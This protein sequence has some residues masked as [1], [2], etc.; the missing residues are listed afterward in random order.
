MYTY[1]CTKGHVEPTPT[2]GALV[3]CPVLE[4]VFVNG[5]RRGAAPC[6]CATIKVPADPVL[7]AAYRIGGP[8][9]VTQELRDRA[10][11]AAQA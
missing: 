6:G 7:E 2:M 8:A 5:Q 3:G 11:A 4:P 10:L 1:I 9:A